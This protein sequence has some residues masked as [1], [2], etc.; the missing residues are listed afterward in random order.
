MVII[1]LFVDAGP[2][3]YLTMLSVVSDE[4]LKLLAIL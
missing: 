1:G 4:C 3:C 2:L